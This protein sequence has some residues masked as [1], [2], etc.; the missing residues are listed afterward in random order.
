MLIPGPLT[1]I[2]LWR[3]VGYFV[4]VALLSLLTECIT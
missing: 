3:T 1:T 2:Y 4:A